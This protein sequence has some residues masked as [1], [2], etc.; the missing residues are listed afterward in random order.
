MIKID[1]PMPS[2]CA[3]CPCFDDTMYGKCNVTGKW[4]DAK[5]GAWFNNKRADWC[6]LQEEK[7]CDV[8]SAMPTTQK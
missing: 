6:P 7:Q 2:R 5:D 1:V 4:L 8:Q 3:N